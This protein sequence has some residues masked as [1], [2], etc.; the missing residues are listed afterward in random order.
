MARQSAL[1]A[2]R[3]AQLARRGASQAPSSSS[4]ATPA[5]MLF[6]IRA[7]AHLLSTVSAGAFKSP[8]GHL[9]RGGGGAL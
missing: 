7:S 8:V 3:A 4:S 6:D 1:R 9:P 2:L 5:R